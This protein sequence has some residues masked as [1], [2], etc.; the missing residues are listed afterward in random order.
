MKIIRVQQTFIVFNRYYFL[1]FKYAKVII[2]PF[3]KIKSFLLTG[4]CYEIRQVVG[5]KVTVGLWDLR[6]PE[7]KDPGLGNLKSDNNQ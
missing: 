5:D 7:S 2:G 4:G 6:R 1:D 3:A